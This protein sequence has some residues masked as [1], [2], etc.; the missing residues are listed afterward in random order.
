LF[1]SDSPW[2]AKTNFTISWILLLF[3]EVALV[4]LFYFTQFFTKKLVKINEKE[5]SSW[6]LP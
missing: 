3:F 2:R 4:Y 1:H 6:T 5:K